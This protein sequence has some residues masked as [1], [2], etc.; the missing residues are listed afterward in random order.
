[1]DGHPFD[2]VLE[3]DGA[4]LLGEDRERV[5]IPLNERLTLLELL[6]VLHLHALAVDDRVAFAIAPLFVLDDE[7]AVAV[8]DDQLAALFVRLDD[9]QPLGVHRPRMARIKG[10]LL[11]HARRRAAD[12]ER[13]H[14]QLRA[15]LADRLRRD[16]ADGLTELDEPAGGEITAVTALADATP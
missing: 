14:R 8:H 7:R 10:L 11:G 16:H 1:M 6:A 15:R 2:D 4:R 5:R 12:V 9:L 3:A 13:P